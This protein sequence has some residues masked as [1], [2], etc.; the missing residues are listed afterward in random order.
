MKFSI[1]KKNKILTNCL[2]GLLV[3]FAFL[4]LQFPFLDGDYFDSDEL[5][6]F[7]GGMSLAHGGDLYV[8]YYA[9]HMP[10]MYYISA[11]F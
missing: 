9:H 11:I 10:L 4:M 7:C 2:I 3:F 6:Y 1:L 8:D 5:E